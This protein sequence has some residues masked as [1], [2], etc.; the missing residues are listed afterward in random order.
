MPSKPID[1]EQPPG[2][3]ASGNVG[4]EGVPPPTYPITEPKKRLAHLTSS[5]NIDFLTVRLM[6][7]KPDSS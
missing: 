5:L 6:E 2:G 7:N 4:I 1:C 3:Q